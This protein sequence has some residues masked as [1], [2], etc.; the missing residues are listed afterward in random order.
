MTIKSGMNPTG[1]PFRLL[2][3][4]LVAMA[5]VIVLSNE[6]VQHPINDWLTWGAIS[7]PIAFLV[8]DTTNRLLGAKNARWVVALGFVIGVALSLLVDVRIAIAS[9][10][11][12]LV[13]QML[14]ISVFNQLR[15]AVWWKAPLV[16]SVIGS[17]VDT[18]LFFSL[19]FAG[20]GLPWI[21]WAWG[22]FGAKL[23]MA[24]TLL[25]VFRLIVT[26]YPARLRL[27]EPA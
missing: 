1:I 20:T 26:Y 9:G 10:S 21:T 27:E 2:L 6:L 15:R 14:D 11:A 17:A 12:F 8:T 23:F 3:P 25:P 7:Y 4:P 13:A 24:A 19:A 5:L 18:A 22:D 16:S